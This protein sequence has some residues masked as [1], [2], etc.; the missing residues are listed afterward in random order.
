MRTPSISSRRSAF[1]YL[2]ASG[3]ASIAMSGATAVG[4]AQ[5]Q[6]GTPAVDAAQVLAGIVD[7][8]RMTTWN[9][10]L[11]AVGGIPQRTA[12]CKRIEA[13][14]FGNGT[15]DGVLRQPPHSAR[16]GLRVRAS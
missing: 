14:S 1:R 5:G 11:Q 13:S 8:A 3:L 9:P 12:I 4:H 10:G 16:R 2:L 6:K 7:P 15:T